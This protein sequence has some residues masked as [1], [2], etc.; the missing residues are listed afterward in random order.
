M[1]DNEEETT[2]L[3]TSSVD[4]NEDMIYAGI[5]GASCLKLIGD[6]SSSG[7]KNH[8]DSSSIADDH[9]LKSGTNDDHSIIRLASLNT[10]SIGDFVD[11]PQ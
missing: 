2:E 3:E 6:D 9:G 11:A 4:L 8:D 7:Q 5:D 10:F 1:L